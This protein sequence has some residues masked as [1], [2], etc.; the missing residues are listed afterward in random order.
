[1][2]RMNFTS[3]HSY[4][5][6]LK[7]KGLITENDNMKIYVASKGRRG[8]RPERRRTKEMGLTGALK[9]LALKETYISGM[10]TPRHFHFLDF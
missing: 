1:M 2:T 7:E 5:E 10:R 3:A 4:L 9:A 8:E 6:R